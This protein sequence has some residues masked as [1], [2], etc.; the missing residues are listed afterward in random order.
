[1]KGK[2]IF[3]FFLYGRQKW[4]LNGNVMFLFLF[5]IRYRKESSLFFILCLFSHV[6]NETCSSLSICN[7][8]SL[9]WR[10]SC[11]S[12]V[13]SGNC[14]RSKATGLKAVI[15]CSMPHTLSNTPYAN[16]TKH[17]LSP[18]CLTGQILLR[19]NVQCTALCWR[20]VSLLL[21]AHGQTA[22]QLF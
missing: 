4:V 6:D 13:F 16:N 7:P 19:L 11:R 20:R 5:L 1:M 18:C 9:Q 2:L 15:R 8:N 14:P 10:L 3:A 12:D 17:M 21:S 22:R